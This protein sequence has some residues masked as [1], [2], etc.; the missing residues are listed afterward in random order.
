MN[1][2]ESGIWILYLWCSAGQNG[3][4]KAPRDVYSEKN[5]DRKKV[6]KQMEY[7]IKPA[8]LTTPAKDEELSELF[9]K[10]NSVPYDDRVNREAKITN[11][12]RGYVEDF[13]RESNSS[14]AQEINSLTLEELLV[15]VQVAN[16]TDANIAIRNI[17]IL[18]FAEHRKP[19]LQCLIMRIINIFKEMEAFL[20]MNKKYK[21]V[22]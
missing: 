22:N 5:S 10:F 7:W 3:P 15:S 19:I 4:Y 8:S 14:L 9:D 18:M 21:L 16:E 13:L 2:K 12:R 6:D 20:W 17:G 11:I 1:Y